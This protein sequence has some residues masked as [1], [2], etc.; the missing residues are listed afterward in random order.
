MPEHLRLW[1]LAESDL[2][3]VSRTVSCHQEIASDG[4]F[5]L[6][7][8]A[9]FGN[10][11]RDLGPWWYRRLSGR[12][13]CLVICCTW[14]QR[15]LVSVL[16]ASAATS[17]MSF[18]TSWYSTDAFQCLYHFTVGRPVDDVR[19]TTLAPYSHLKKKSIPA[20]P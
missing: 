15:L 20:G 19:L 11:I 18:M 12:P 9:E 3:E 8:L 2:R 14:K 7:M 13:V 1:C 5:S 17:T 4:A 16:P 6:G 10:T